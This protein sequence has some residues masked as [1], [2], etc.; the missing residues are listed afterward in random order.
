[1]KFESIKNEKF[2]M[3]TSEEL[4]QIKGGTAPSVVLTYDD[5][6]NDEEEKD[7]YAD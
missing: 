5:V 7:R 1:M 2:E 3:L 6:R 4:N